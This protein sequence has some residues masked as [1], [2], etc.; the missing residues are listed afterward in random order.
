MGEKDP[1]EILGVA[2]S[3][4]QDEI[5]RAYR[6]LAKQYHPDRNRNDPSATARFKEVQAAY[7]VIGDPQRR[8]EF[9]RFGAGGPVPEYQRWQSHPGAGADFSGADIPF[10]NLG[11]LSS[12]FEQFFQRGGAGTA[13]RGR[14][15]SRNSNRAGGDAG[16][17]EHA[18]DLSFEEAAQGTY[19]EVSISSNGR[20]E[21][22]KVRI[23]AGI[24]NGK[25]VRVSG[26]GRYTAT[27][28][29]NLVIT[30]RVRPHAFFR[31]EGSDLLLE[32]PIGVT[33]AL[34]GTKVEIPTLSGNRVLLTIPPGTSSGSKLRIREQGVRDLRTKKNGDLLAVIRVVAPREISDD[35]KRLATELQSVLRELPRSDVPWR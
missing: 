21:H 9:D 30:C 14:R 24:E 18:V 35:A 3:A 1:Y 31:R 20:A 17:L 11:D 32:V 34:L 2:R 22:I 8:E 15:Q 27:G 7:D 13:A 23:P 4:S 12:I 19:R 29:G 28:R 33:E 5:K 10:E 26:K 16:T 25:K 6:Q